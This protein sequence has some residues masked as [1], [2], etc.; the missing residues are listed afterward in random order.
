L[1]PRKAELIKTDGEIK[2]KPENVRQDRLGAVK[3]EG[4]EQKSLNQRD[5]PLNDLIKDGPREKLQEEEIAR[6]LR[7]NRLYDQGVLLE[8]LARAQELSLG[9]DPE[10]LQGR[11]VFKELE[12]VHQHDIEANISS[13]LLTKDNLKQCVKNLSGGKVIVL[14]DLLIDEFI[15]GNAV[16]ISREAPVLILE[17]MDTKL[18]P[19]GAAN[20]AHN[21]AALGG[22]CHAVGVCGEDEYADKLASILE[23][24]KISHSL[25][26]DRTRAT[27]VKTRV[28]S[29]THAVMQQLLR[30]DRISHATIDSVVETALISKLE[31]V[32]G[33][34][35]ALIM[36]DYRA[37]TI[38]DGIVSA[39][40]RLA[41][42]QKLL[43]IV[44]AQ[45]R[46]ERFQ[47][48]TMITPNEPD[49]EGAV[50]YEFTSM[51][52]LNQAGNDLL[53]LTGAQAVLITR[54]ANGMALFCKDKK[55]FYLAPFNKSEVFDVTGAGDTVVAVVT[56]ALVTG[57]RFEEAIALGNLAAGIVVKKLGTAVTS[58]E[59]MLEHLDHLEF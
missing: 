35:S 49:A 52:N 57:A 24:H 44:D 29:K 1:Q 32:V 42:K 21:V 4:D 3:Q 39:C 48:V 47:E 12:R 7:S 33:Q 43:I 37:G 36:S 59:E 23:R 8:E 18:I 14:G 41:Q 25:V 9:L 56:L 51:E 2:G 40:K 53:L 17:H 26:R 22:I 13:G 34:Y 6:Q 30:L 15:E 31:Q 19:G 10:H 50:G 16:R 45:E 27:T 28:L 54:G 20:T 58:Q 38:T 55:P 11:Q 46:F 5:K